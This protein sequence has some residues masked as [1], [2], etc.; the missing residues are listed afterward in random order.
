MKKYLILLGIIEVSLM[1]LSIKPTYGLVEKESLSFPMNSNVFFEKILTNEI[2]FNIKKI[3][4]NEYCDYIKSPQK[5]KAI[6][7]FKKD[8]QKY[9]ETKTTKEE[10]LSTILKGFAI[11][12]V[13]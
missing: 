10:A 6:Y 7:L 2:D 3:C 1:L 8:Y 12:K 11:T 9:L 13:E 4:A 5:E